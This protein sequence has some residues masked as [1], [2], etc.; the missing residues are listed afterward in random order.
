MP[1]IITY[2][3]CPTLTAR[4]NLSSVING[5]AMRF[6]APV[7]EPHV[8]VFTTA[9][10][11]KDPAETLEQLRLDGPLQLSVRGLDCTDE[12]TKTLFI[13]FEPDAGLSRLSE[14]LR[15]RA[16][17][18]SEDE[19]NPHLSLIYKDMSPHAKQE[20]AG[21]IYIPFSEIAFDSIKAV[22]SPAKITSREDVESWRTV[23]ER[24][25]G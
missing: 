7:F 11:D 14:E 22:L 23:A 9:V 25:L 6:D 21:Q 2:W 18:E 13:Q 24:S 19:L 17:T 16:G 1:Q 12:F 4:G 8:T 10:L 3:L 15:S 20:L 5:L